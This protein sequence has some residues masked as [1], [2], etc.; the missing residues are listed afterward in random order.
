LIWIHGGYN[1]YT[2]LI[3]KL[4]KKKKSIITLNI[5]NE[6]IPQLLVKKSLK[7]LLFKFILKQL[8]F[9]HCNWYGTENLFIQK[10]FKNTVVLLWG[11]DKSYFN[12]TTHKS[13]TKNQFVSQFLMSLP[14]NKT[15]FFY[16]KSI[17][18]ASRHDI[19][20]ESLKKLKEREINS[21][22]VYFWLGNV[23]DEGEYQKLKRKIKFY[24]LEENIKI[25]QHPF[26]EIE[27]YKEIWNFM[28][29]GLQ[30]AERD[31]LSSTFTEPLALKKEIIATK[32]ESYII[33]EKKF[34]LEL[35]LV[36]IDPDKIYKRILNFLEGVRT[37]EKE[38]HLRYNIMQK[39][40]CFQ[41]NIQHALDFYLD[42]KEC[43]N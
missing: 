38:I 42:A 30:I 19:L 15:K 1:P 33:F 3:F 16:P 5:W 39:H 25:I 41:D 6:Y 36:E 10:G 23:H 2:L 17:T 28:D 9:I 11:L 37:N 20:V 4:L 18:Q 27:E 43:N 32:I 13:V 21:F 34:K 22:I 14:K 40:Y 8:D 12:K 24:N 7:S 31:Q 35:N 29:C 26:L